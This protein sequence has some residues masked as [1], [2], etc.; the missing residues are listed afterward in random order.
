MFCRVKKKASSDGNIN[1]LITFGDLQQQI[2]EEWKAAVFET[3][4]GSFGYN[5]RSV[6]LSSF[7]GPVDRAASVEVRAVAATKR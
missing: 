4:A 5:E 6:A 1:P 7:A 3:V 2:R